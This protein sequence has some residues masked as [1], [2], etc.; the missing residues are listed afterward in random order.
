MATRPHEEVAE[1]RLELRSV[2]FNIRCHPN[3]VYN[4]M[5]IRSQ[6][7]LLPRRPHALR[8]E[9]SRECAGSRGIYFEPVN[10]FTHIYNHLTCASLSFISC[11]YLGFRMI[12]DEF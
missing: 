11:D 7:C 12:P 4:H 1:L 10:S 8:K 2:S 5:S 9:R 3:N 6:V